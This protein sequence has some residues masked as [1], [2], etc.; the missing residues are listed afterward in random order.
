MVFDPSGVS[1]V[2]EKSEPVIQLSKQSLRKAG[3]R[4]PMQI[5]PGHFVLCVMI[6]GDLLERVRIDT[7]YVTGSD[8]VHSILQMT[9]K[10]G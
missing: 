9:F 7:G 10:D 6:G 1:I 5:A 4:F 8:C 2:M 3:A